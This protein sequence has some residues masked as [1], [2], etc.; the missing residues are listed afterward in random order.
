V[1][2]LDEGSGPSMLIAR[3]ED[4]VADSEAYIR[5]ILEFY[6]LAAPIKLPPRDGHAHFRSGKPAE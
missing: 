6:G 1:N 2:L 4:L 5:S 3:Y